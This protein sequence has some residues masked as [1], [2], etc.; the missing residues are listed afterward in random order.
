MSPPIESAKNASPARQKIATNQGSTRTRTHIRPHTGRRRHSHAE[1][2]SRIA[3]VTI[4]SPTNIRISGPL[5][6][7]PPASAVQKI[8]GHD[9]GGGPGTSPPRPHPYTHAH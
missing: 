3:S 2:R 7:I 5:S 9:H 1:D 6:R 8:A 4:V